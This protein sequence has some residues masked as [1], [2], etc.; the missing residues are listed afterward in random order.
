MVISTTN[1]STCRAAACLLNFFYLL[2]GGV[3]CAVY[4]VFC[5]GEILYV[6]HAEIFIEI[7]VCTSFGR[8]LFF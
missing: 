7:I 5:F 4:S 6:C 1:E 3:N 8:L 2:N